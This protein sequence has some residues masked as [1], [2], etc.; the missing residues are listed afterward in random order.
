LDD[1]SKGDEATT[2]A[3]DEPMNGITAASEK[4]PVE[5][6]VTT[7]GHVDHP[8]TELTTTATTSVPPPTTSTTTTSIPAQPASDPS[9]DPAALSEQPW[10]RFEILLDIA[11]GISRFKVGVEDKVKVAGNACDHVSAALAFSVIYL[12]RVTVD[13]RLTPNRFG[14]ASLGDSTPI[15]HSFPLE[16]FYPPSPLPPQ[17]VAL[18][19]DK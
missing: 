18:P 17:L 3:V 16:Q 4:L 6:T 12:E 1:V 5:D 19:I 15:S 10:D 7:N 14:N 13:S 9:T 8:A 11:E 2:S